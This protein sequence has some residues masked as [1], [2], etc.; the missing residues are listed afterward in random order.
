MK[1]FS[2]DS[3]KTKATLVTVA[4]I[5]HA[6]KANAIPGFFRC[7]LENCSNACEICF[8]QCLSPL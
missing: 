3:R 7:S 2:I 6:Y 4:V 8:Q 5:T 1:R